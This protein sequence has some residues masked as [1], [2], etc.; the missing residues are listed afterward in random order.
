MLK[1]SY[2]LRKSK[3]KTFF[4][5]TID[6]DGMSVSDKMLEENVCYVLDDDKSIISL[7]D[8]INRFNDTCESLNSVIYNL[9]TYAES[10]H[11]KSENSIKIIMV[12][13]AQIEY[14]ER[15]Y[16]ILANIEK[17]CK[18]HTYFKTISA[19]ILSSAISFE[20]THTQMSKVLAN[21]LS[22][23]SYK[24]KPLI[25]DGMQN[26]I[27][28]VLASTLKIETQT[29]RNLRAFV[30]ENN[31]MIA[32]NNKDISYKNHIIAIDT[33]IHGLSNIRGAHIYN[34][35]SLIF[36][37]KHLSNK[38]EYQNNLKKWQEND[39]EF[40]AKI[41]NEIGKIYKCDL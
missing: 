9:R 22:K 4:S 14:E 1:L 36:D 31:Y 32:L 28:Y 29:A 39:I 24:Y 21:L 18:K 35:Y 37:M 17:I 23:R 11:R 19:G 27:Y 5:I 10:T 7:H 30:L 2:V 34:C 15:I 26:S 38:I 20:K 41:K 12:L 13:Y 25:P 3:Y 16:K 8:C 33:L 6:I 40:R